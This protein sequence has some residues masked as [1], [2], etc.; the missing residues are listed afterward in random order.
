M[1]TQQQQNTKAYKQTTTA[2]NKLYST[3]KSL[4]HLRYRKIKKKIT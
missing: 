1:M 3:F 4:S 2:N